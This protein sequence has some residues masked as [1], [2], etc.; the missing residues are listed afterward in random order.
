MPIL[1]MHLPQLSYRRH[2]ALLV[3][4]VLS[5]LILVY[6]LS[7]N[8]SLSTLITFSSPFIPSISFLRG[9]ASFGVFGYCEDGC[10]RGAP[11]EWSPA[12]N[13]S[14][15]GVMLLWP[16]CA[17]VGEEQ[18]NAGMASNFLALVVIGFSC[19]PGSQVP[20]YLAM[21]VS[22][23]TMYLAWLL[24]I[25][26]WSMARRGLAIGETKSELGSWV[27]GW[28][29]PPVGVTERKTRRKTVR[30]RGHGPA[31][32]TDE[33]YHYRRTTREFTPATRV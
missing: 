12:I 4:L 33:Y 18:S 26:G 11:Y 20:F 10:M 30:H 6:V 31:Q 8:C 22:T 32:Q 28:P 16:I 14:L 23:T 2:V 15:T 24:G 19:V 9:P 29:E 21:G 17:F 1:T 7:R 13:A 25:F 27:V 5:S 3:A